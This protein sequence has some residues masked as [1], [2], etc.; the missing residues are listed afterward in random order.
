MLA[1]KVT[2]SFIPG[3]LRWNERRISQNFFILVD[4]LDSKDRTSLKQQ[5]YTINSSNFHNLTNLW[6]C[7]NNFVLHLLHRFK[8]RVKTFLKTCL[9]I[10]FFTT[11]LTTLRNNNNQIGENLNIFCVEFSKFLLQSTKKF[12]IFIL[13]LIIHCRKT[14]F[15]SLN[16]DVNVFFKVSHAA[17][18]KILRNILIKLIFFIFS[19]Q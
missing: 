2:V 3:E 12:K 17:A 1:G 18:F 11:I 5:T 15:P 6:T 8:N 4:I 14:Y 7:R 19:F 16:H 10:I 9:Q 13:W